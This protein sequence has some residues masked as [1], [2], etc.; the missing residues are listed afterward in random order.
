MQCS[1]SLVHGRLSSA[2]LTAAKAMK[3]TTVA[4]Q[5]AKA[6]S[7]LMFPPLSMDRRSLSDCDGHRRADTVGQAAEH[8]RIRAR[9]TGHGNEHM[10][11][12][13]QR[14]HAVAIGVVERRP[15]DE[16]VPAPDG[17]GRVGRGAVDGGGHRLA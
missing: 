2:W 16:A 6:S 17:T 10:L 8:R 1:E 3:P 7:F 13:A 9:T 11:R 15:P 14:T 5:V 12:T 4:K